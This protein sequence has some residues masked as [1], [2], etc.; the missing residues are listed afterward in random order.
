MADTTADQDATKS[1]SK[2]KIILFA[3]S[4]FLASAV[5]G[6]FLMYSDTVFSSSDQDLDIET[7][8]ASKQVYVA[9]PDTVVALPN[10][11]DWKQLRLR[12]ELEVPSMY[13]TEVRN[14]MPRI[15]DI[16]ND[17]LRIL[18]IDQLA[19][20]LALVRIRLHMLHRAKIVVGEEK[21]K[22]IFITEFVLN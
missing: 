16:L 20:S 10:A 14:A 19:D 1:N 8:N 13:E 18:T 22:D 5:G 6:F 9:L 12:A 15:M 17:Y 7:T 11:G 2:V 21:I 3:V 4:L